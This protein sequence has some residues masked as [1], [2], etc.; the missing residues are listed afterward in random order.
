MNI[1]I[2][3]G[4][5]IFASGIST[6]LATSCN[7]K[8]VT[9]D[10]DYNI[11][12]YNKKPSKTEWYTSDRNAERIADLF[13]PTSGTGIHQAYLDAGFRSPDFQSGRDIKLKP[14]D[15]TDGR[16]NAL[17]PNRIFLTPE[18]L[19]STGHNTPAC[20][21]LCTH[22]LHHMVQYEYIPWGTYL[23]SLY[24]F[25]VEGTAVAA[26]DALLSSTDNAWGY[27]GGFYYQAYSY[28]RGGHSDY[29]WGNSGYEGGLFWKYLMEQYGTWRS[30]PAVGVD[31]LRKFYN[32]SDDN[33]EGFLTTIQDLLDDRDRY[34]TAATDTHV[35][36]R[37]LFQD[38][39]IANWTRRYRNPHSYASAYSIDV[40]DP[41][42]F[43]YYDEN[44][45]T[46]TLSLY[47][48]YS[49]DG[50]W[51]AV[52]SEST[53]GPYEKAEHNLPPA[54]TTGIKT[55]SAAKYAAEYIRCNLTGTP[56]GTYGIGFW[57]ESTDG[58]KCWFS[59]I[60]VRQSGSVD[61]I[62]KGTTSPDSGNSFHYA[63]MQNTS[64]PYET[65][66]AVVTGEAGESVDGYTY[67]TVDFDYTFSY[68][69]PTVE[70]RDPTTE[71]K[72]YVGDADNPDR[73]IVR[74][75]VESPDYLGSGS[76][77]GLSPED[78]T[79]YV[80]NLAI[81][82]NEATIISAAHVLGD[83]WLTVQAPVKSPK[84]TIPLSLIVYLGSNSDT[85][86]N[87]VVYEHLEVDQMLVIDRSGSMALTSGSIERIEA[88]R[89]AAQ[90]FIDASGSDDQ[91]GI[92]R[93]NGD[94]NE[95]D[96]TSYADG[97]VIYSLQLMNSQFE[98]DLVNLLIDETNYGGDM[99]QPDGYTSIGDGLYWGAKEIVDNGKPE[100]EKWIV[101]LSDGH[102]NEDS[103]F[104]LQEAFLTGLGVH[105]ETIALG[106]G[107][108]KNL[109]QTIADKT[110]GRYYEVA[111]PEGGSSS[112]MAFGS[113]AVS[114]SGQS[115]ML[116]LADTFLLS[117][118][119][120]HKRD[121]IREAWLSVPAGASHNITL[122]LAEGG[123]EDAVISL[124]ASTSAADVD[125]TITDPDDAV[126]PAPDEGYTATNPDGSGH[127]WD[128][129][130]VSY[131]MAAMTNGT[132][133]FAVT[134]AG[135][136]TADCLFVLSAK[137]KEGVQSFLYFAQ[138]HG[139]DVVYGE[140]GKFLRGLPMPIVAVLTDGLG[141]V[142][143]ADTTVTIRHPNRPPVTLRLRD[144][145]GSYDGAANDGVYAAVFS[146]TT[147]AS[148]S[149]QSPNEETPL[150]I[151]GSYQVTLNATGTD[152]NGRAFER[153]DRGSFHL[154]EVE[155]GLG[156]DS[157]G[158]GMPTRYENL[159]NGVNPGIAD[160]GG[161]VD[162]DTL[163]NGS[164]Y[165][166]G[167]DPN[168]IDTDGGGETDGSE[169]LHG[170][171]PLDYS[172][173]TV[174]HLLLARVLDRFSDWHPP[175]T[176]T[177]YVL[178]ANQ[179]MILF[180]PERGHHTIELYRGT[181]ATGPFSKISTI[182][183]VTNTGG[184]Y[185]DKGLSNGTPYHYYLQPYD[186]AGR[187]GVPT[188]IFSGTPRIDPNPP[189]GFLSINNGDQFTTT[190]NV[191][192]RLLV[193]PDVTQMKLALH[194]NLDALPWVPF[195]AAITNFSIGS[196]ADGVQSFV[197]AQVRDA[198]GNETLLADIIIY[199]DPSSVGLIRGRAYTHQDI[200]NGNIGITVTGDGYQE[201]LTDT[202]GFFDVYM[203]P[204]L[205]HVY[206]DA[207]GYQSRVVS[208]VTLSAS[209]TVSLPVV[210]LIPLDSDN[211]TLYDAHELAIYDTD[212]YA[213]DTDNDSINDNH[214][215]FVT[216]TDP[217]NPNSVLR[218]GMPGTNAGG[219]RTVTW[220]SV[221]SVTY[222]L[223]YKDSLAD[224][225]WTYLATVPAAAGQNTTTYVD[226]GA[227]REI[228]RFYLIRVLP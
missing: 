170:S 193:S 72:A 58:C 158:D 30:E 157:D 214:E 35:E 80:G 105:V 132:W 33:R 154:Y 179:N 9:S 18:F 212:R 69:L 129:S 225:T 171:N 177:N 223:Y 195:K 31:V 17:F 22:E 147:E 23:L 114:G 86:E 44:P 53:T 83:Y 167:T 120:I 5:W 143:G 3:L 100:A 126:V 201:T 87:A 85:K 84:P 146:A 47:S 40:S 45:A 221:E 180:S 76:V 140:N 151:T 15:I 174:A 220:Q 194:D 148:S 116:D 48:V 66:I 88:A 102:Q 97:E 226:T 7:E 54:S 37:D 108:D 2:M 207:R 93:F 178:K 185:L 142:I 137:N 65:L 165:M 197:F 210:H 205:Y 4:V 162:G 182:T 181:A 130:Y 156:G 112:S 191:A 55:S 209:A 224:T 109:L 89:S 222:T 168:A 28:L 153:V 42:R 74:V 173:D 56:S 38:F 104:S 186:A 26:E 49:Y 11:H 82:T 119:R 216:L 169:I 75:N 190:T 138:F 70:I 215:L 125:L 61:L 12:Y 135:T 29:L 43:Y 124:Y 136:T 144:D 206:F 19:N 166:S 62:S 51:N 34:S 211:D 118:E 203:D 228:K 91:I 155:Q 59:L 127:Y 107:C 10:Y 192:V 24:P 52:T 204:G 78:F 27:A 8:I 57:T 213:E 21:L 36:L 25:A 39:T 139:D 200:H 68:F 160:A 96:A 115:M 161:D 184:V 131:R 123:L 41:G 122:T 101:L 16:S 13:D 99:L 106:S 128:P 1:R 208:N 219:E 188:P 202:N 176:E 103:D 163:S 71:Y 198:A 199:R 94:E 187:Q 189:D 113:M 134:N 20:K 152:N 64:D 98:R 73:F 110:A 175:E 218:F 92:V 164:E 121:R 67:L 149:G 141:P 183:V 63:T 145:G 111:A 6:I 60:G 196:P 117:S 150:L 217:L 90:L 227:T 133:Q 32:L 79:V 46:A 81:P 50:K 95:P 14:S 172:D 77:T 159:H